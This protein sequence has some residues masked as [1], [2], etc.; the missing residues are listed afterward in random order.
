VLFV[1]SGLQRKGLHHLLLAWHR[2]RLTVVARVVDPGLI[3]L[4]QTTRGVHDRRGETE[5]ELRQLY[6][7]AT[8]FAMPSL[9]EGFGQVY[10]EAL[11]Q[12]LPV[13]GTRNTCLPDIG[14]EEDGIFLTTPG[15]IDELVALLE[16]LCVQLDN[17]TAIRDKAADRAR[18]FTSARFRSTLRDLI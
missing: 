5:P 6:S 7:A 3:P 10:L 1:G 9:V 14:G 4:L 16:R 11:A 13:I 18:Q 2:A 15:N 17:N 8:V 12:G